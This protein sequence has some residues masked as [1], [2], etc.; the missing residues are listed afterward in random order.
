[1]V[2]VRLDDPATDLINIIDTKR[3]VPEVVALHEQNFGTRKTLPDLL[4][5][6]GRIKRLLQ[7]DLIDTG[8]LGNDGLALFVIADQ[9]RCPSPGDVIG[10]DSA[11][12]EIRDFARLLQRFEMT[13]IEEIA[14][15]EGV[16]D[17][18]N[19]PNA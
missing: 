15:H 5:I 19:N 18:H 6:F 3:T 12:M 17:L 1:M 14:D 8:N 10:N 16:S 9:R 7:Y 2:K 4:E 11:Y 13:I